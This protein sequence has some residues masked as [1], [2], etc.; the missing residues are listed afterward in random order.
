MSVHRRCGLTDRRGHWPCSR[1]KEVRAFLLPHDTELINTGWLTLDGTLRVLMYQGLFQGHGPTGQSETVFAHR[2][3]VDGAV[4]LNVA[5]LCLD[6]LL[7][8]GPELA[9]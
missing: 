7:Q 4:L 5:A 9:A 6:H 1:E 8:P 2:L 3:Q